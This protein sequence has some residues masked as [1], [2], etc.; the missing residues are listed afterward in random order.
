MGHHAGAGLAHVLLVL[1]QDPDHEAARV[2]SRQV[3]GL[4]AGLSGSQ[5]KS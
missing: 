1:V 5:S 2:V 4:A 3:R